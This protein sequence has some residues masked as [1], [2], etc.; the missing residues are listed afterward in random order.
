MYS[1]TC[2]GMCCN[3]EAEEQLRHQARAD[4]HDLIH[5]HSRSLQGLLATTADALRGK[6]NIFYH[7][8]NN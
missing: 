8:L 2:D 6:S 1:T 3:Q 7:K 4:F 5:H